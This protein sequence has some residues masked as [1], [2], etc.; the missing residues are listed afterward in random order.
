MITLF[1]L[2][3]IFISD[4]P[5][6]P[7]LDKYKNEKR[8]VTIYWTPSFDGESPIT[9]YTIV[10]E[11]T[12]YPFIRK[13]IAIAATNSCKIAKLEPYTEYKVWIKAKNEIGL[14]KSSNAIYVQT[15]QDGNINQ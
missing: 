6:P 10:Y 9:G 15:A 5:D 7:I 1:Y 12:T 2:K 13:Y 14:S 3:L 11:G 4:K 8:S